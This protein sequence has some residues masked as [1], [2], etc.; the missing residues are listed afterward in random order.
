VVKPV[1]LAKPVEPVEPAKPA[2]PA[3]PAH[4]RSGAAT[5]APGPT[6]KN[7]CPSPPASNTFAGSAVQFPK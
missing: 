3:K 7:F 1:E 4:A 5:M 6:A 2:K